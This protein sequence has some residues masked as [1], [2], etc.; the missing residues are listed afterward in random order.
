MVLTIDSWWNPLFFLKINCILPVSLSFLLSVQISTSSQEWYQIAWQNNMWWS[1]AHLKFGGVGLP[2]LDSGSSLSH[3]VWKEDVMTLMGYYFPLI[4]LLQMQR[5]SEVRGSRGGGGGRAWRG[6]DS[7]IKWGDT[8]TP[9]YR[10]YFYPDKFPLC[11]QLYLY[12]S[13]LVVFYIGS[14]LVA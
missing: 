4:G 10:Y 3:K 7:R 2:F 14:S 13:P 1:M 11:V 6:G 5:A 9:G 12:S 8:E